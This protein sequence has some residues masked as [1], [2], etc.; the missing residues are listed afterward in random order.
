MVRWAVN[1]SNIAQVTLST[2]ATGSRN[3]RS[4]F[5]GI[6]KNNTSGDWHLF[7]NLEEK[8]TTT[9]DFSLAEIYYDALKIGYLTSKTGM[10]IF[11]DDSARNAEIVAPIH[12]TMVYRRD[13][14]VQEIYTGSKWDAIDPIHPFLLMGV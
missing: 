3:T 9:V 1:I 10:N 4:K 14:R 7:S 12:G 2:T 6:V 8:P 13:K 5:S 11:V